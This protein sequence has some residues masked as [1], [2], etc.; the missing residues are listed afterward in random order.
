M[1]QNKENDDKCDEAVPMQTRQTTGRSSFLSNCQEKCFFIL[2]PLQFSLFQVEHGFC[3]FKGCKRSA[4]PLWLQFPSP[5][6]CWMTRMRWSTENTKVKTDF[7][8]T[9][10]SFSVC[11][12]IVLPS[13]CH[14]LFFV[15]RHWWKWWKRSQ[16]K[17]GKKTQFAHIPNHHITRQKKI[18]CAMCAWLVL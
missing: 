9:F 12:F 17:V 6:S 7:F 2:R 5:L 8:L 10:F 15:C 16:Q 14:S 1:S 18:M 13:P 11:Y 4:L 3:A